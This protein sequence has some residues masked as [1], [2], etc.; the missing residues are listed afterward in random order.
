MSVSSLVDFFFRLSGFLSF[1]RRLWP[2]GDF[3]RCGIIS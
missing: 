3:R 2:L 1:M